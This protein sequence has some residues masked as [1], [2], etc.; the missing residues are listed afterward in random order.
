MFLVNFENPIVIFDTETGGINHSDVIEWDF[1]T[2]ERFNFYKPGQE[3]RGI[4]K[5]AANPILEIAAIK[6]NPKN[7]NKIDSFHSYLGPEHNQTFEEY[8]ATCN[9]EALRINKL[10]DNLD[11]IRNARPG[12]EVLVDFI[13]WAVGNH[14]YFIPCGKN[15]DFDIKMVQSAC[16]KFCISNGLNYRN[17][18]Y[19][20]ELMSYAIYYFNLPD[21]PIIPNYELSTICAA[22]GIDSSRAH[23]AMFDVEMTAECFKV[24]FKKFSGN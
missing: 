22:L 24:I 23:E 12:S 21:T 10:G 13:K 6:Y 8:L 19:P 15:I 11:L 17:M 20:L 1:P 4:I 7:F 5:E 3:V 14:K 9:P 2:L 16:T 18:G